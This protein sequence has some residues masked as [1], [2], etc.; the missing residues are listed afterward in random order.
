LATGVALSATVDDAGS[1]SAGLD[2]VNE[3]DVSN[4]RGE[5]VVD[6]RLRF[7]NLDG[8]DGNVFEMFDA[9]AGT[10]EQSDPLGNQPL[11]PILFGDE[12]CVLTHSSVARMPAA[13]DLLNASPGPF[14]PFSLIAS[15]MSGVDVGDP[16]RNGTPGLVARVDTDS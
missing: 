4:P 11:E 15:D 3:F 5:L 10:L 13:G 8:D 9:G 14:D 16:V 1:G 6:G 7:A 12:V 2:V